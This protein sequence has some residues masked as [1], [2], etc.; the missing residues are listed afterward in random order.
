MERELFI[1]H[2]YNYFGPFVERSRY[3]TIYLYLNPIILKATK[4]VGSFTLVDV[5]NEVIINKYNEIYL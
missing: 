2:T 4:F 1:Q 3:D 5:S